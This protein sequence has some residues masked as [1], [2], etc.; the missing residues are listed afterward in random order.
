[1]EPSSH[2]WRFF[3]AGGFDQPCIET[4]ADLVALPGLDQKLWAVLSCPTV[5]LE[6][7]AKTLQH[8]DTDGDGRVRAPELLAAVVWAAS[9]LKDADELTRGA[10]ALPLAA[11]NDA[12]PEGKRLL[13]TA[14]DI[15]ANRGRSGADSIDLD[16]TAES[17]KIFAALKLNGDGIVPADSADSEAVSRLI[18]EIIDALGPDFDRSGKFGVS[19]EKLDAFIVELKA[20]SEWWTKAEQDVA[21]LPLGEDTI[22]AAEAFTAVAA[23]IDDYFTRCRLATF[24][25]RAAEPLNASLYDY[26]VLAA[27]VL[28]ES[29][30]EAEQ[31]PLVRVEAGKPL[32]LENGMNPAWSGRIERFRRLVAAPLLGDRKELTFDDWHAI[33]A[34][35]APYLAWT[36]SR[37]G[38]S[39]E[40][41]GK[42]RVREILAGTDCDELAALIAADKAREAEATNI[43]ALDRLVRYNR[44]LHRLLNNFVSLRDFYTRRANGIFQF[45][46]LYIDGRSCTLCL[47]V[48]N[49]AKHAL[50]ATMSRTFLLYCDCLRRGSNEK[51][52]IAA[53]VT[54]GDSANLMVG[55]NGLFYDASGRD[56]DATIVHIIENPISIRQAAF[57]PYR[58][59]ARL[60]SEQVQ[61]IAAAKDKTV[62]DRAAIGVES[63]AKDLDKGK[64]QP[65]P[66]DVGKF[67][68]IFA[69]IGLAVG[70]I[71]TAVASLL[72]GFLTLTW[73][74]MPIAFAGLA[75]VISGPSMIMAWFKLRSRT[76][77][78]IL[79]AN[80]WAVNTKAKI[81]MMFGHVLT[82]TAQ[83][84]VGTERS[85]QDPFSDKKFPWSTVLL[86]IALLVVGTW[87]AYRYY[88]GR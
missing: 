19:R 71:G 57:S 42:A 1:M 16:D 46:T 76:L 34:R 78:P 35:F 17:E 44:H 33:K 58:R 81:N 32:S 9:M 39:V 47:R 49:V 79:D 63:A 88:Y 8:I 83:L 18:R 52:T 3:R 38:A 22:A 43:G 85:L 82:G 64:T 54:A 73:W 55:R 51:M 75:L 86:L 41:L 59:A 20:F 5:G 87:F 74:K 50:I 36:A 25:D 4:G 62:T 6:F 61:K 15:L 10:D 7:D 37:S 69:A 40:K 45:G 21:V 31:F 30:P 66:F 56:W 72:G 26:A 14:R 77:A 2:K 53:A 80:G 13:T 68:G 60:I 27:K 84:P 24:D 48:E 23:K 12:I 11:I 70:A 29:S 28:S 67:A 65:P